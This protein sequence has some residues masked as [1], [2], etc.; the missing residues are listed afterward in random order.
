[1]G[2]SAT[3]RAALLRTHSMPQHLQPMSVVTSRGTVRPLPCLNCPAKS[4][5][6]CKPLDY[7]LQKELFE[8]GH[9]RK[10]ESRQFLFCV[11]SPAGSLFKIV[12]GTVAVSKG[13]PDG[14][15]QIIALAFPGEVCGYTAKDGHYAYDGE[16][17]GPV[18]ACA[19]DRSRFNS[20]AQRHPEVADAMAVVLL[21]KL[22][23]ARLHLTVIGQLTSTERLASFLSM[24]TVEYSEHGFQVRPLVMPMKRSDVS[25]YLGLRIE[26]ISRAFTKLRKQRLIELD[27]EDNIII[28]DP[29]R[30]LRLGNGESDGVQVS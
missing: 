19:F 16:A 25:E 1:M 4:R 24:L 3:S 10:W 23:R 8:L 5:N 29:V 18:V 7:D 20:F 26:T 15:R 27:D 22:E 21:E 13:L 14:R 6:V 2:V 28:C 17:I 12:S 11:G 9:Q 30:L